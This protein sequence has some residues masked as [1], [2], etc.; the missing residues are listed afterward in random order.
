MFFVSLI[1][2]ASSQNMS[3]LHQVLTTEKTQLVC[4]SDSGMIFYATNSATDKRVVL[5]DPSTGSSTTIDTGYNYISIVSTP[6]GVYVGCD[7][8]V[9]KYTSGGTFVNTMSCL[10]LGISPYNAGIHSITYDPSTNNMYFG[11]LNKVVYTT[12]NFS[13]ISNINP[14]LLTS[15]NTTAKTLIFKQDTLFIGL[16][17]TPS[18]GSS[19]VIYVVGNVSSPYTSLNIG[20]GQ[21][22]TDA[23]ETNG[24]LY[25]TRDNSSG[26]ISRND[27]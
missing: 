10:S 7:M 3:N 25:F 23:I 15:G 19:S 13:F 8:K 21:T 24:D 27:N 9:T 12:E 4:Y 1:V 20:T 2:T 16:Y 17:K 6:F 14:I 22:C 11:T 18:S 5:Y 26:V